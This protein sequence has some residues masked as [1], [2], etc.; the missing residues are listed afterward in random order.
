MGVYIH[1]E[2]T[3][4]QPKHTHTKKQ[5]QQAHSQALR[6]TRICVRIVSVFHLSTHHLLVV[7]ASDVVR[8]L[9]IVSGSE[10]CAADSPVVGIP[11]TVTQSSATALTVVVQA[12]PE[13]TVA[14]RNKLCVQFRGF[15]AFYE[16]GVDILA[17]G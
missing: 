15:G 13:H 17:G 2:K 10:W 5:Q 7:T 16:S 11:G 6:H 12:A 14:S 1:E 8:V 9:P 4:K 3:Y